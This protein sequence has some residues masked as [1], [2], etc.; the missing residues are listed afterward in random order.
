MDFS[1]TLYPLKHLELA[2]KETIF[3]KNFITNPNIDVGDYT[4]YNDMKNPEKF[5]K[6]NVR[7][8]YFSK[9]IIG[10]FCQIAHGTTFILNDANHP[11][12]GFSTYPFFAFGNDWGNYEPKLT[13]KSDTLIGNDVWF[14]HES[15]VLPGVQ[16]G[17]GAIIGACSVVTKN[18]PPYA[19]VG[20]NPAKIIRMRFEEETVRSLLQIQW[21]NWDIEKITKNIPAIVGCDISALQKL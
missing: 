18:V 3:L 9:L 2:A 14:G 12:E 19:I 6:Q 13:Q 15:R 5:E 1:T 8:G 7:F 10:K 21:W 16:I 4:Y 17:D 20:G 11:L